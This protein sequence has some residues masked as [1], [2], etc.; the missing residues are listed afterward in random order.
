MIIKKRYINTL[1]AVGIAMILM[2]PFVGCGTNKNIASG[3]TWEVTE[4]T[5]LDSLTI[6]EGA[7]I[8]APEG[9]QLTLT[10]DGVETGIKP[11]TYKGKIV[12]TPT[13]NIP[14]T[15]NMHGVPYILRTGIYVDNGVIVPQKSVSAAVVGGTVTNT[16]A[17]DVSIT[18]I[19]ENFNGIFVTGDSKSS[20]S[21]IN[22][23]INF[24]GNGGSDF[25]ANGAALTSY[26]KADVTVNNASIITNGVI[27]TAVWVGGESTMHVN[28]SNIETGNPALPPGHKDQFTEGGHVMRNVPFMLGLTGTCRSTNLI[29]SGT[30]YYT[31]THIK[32]QGWGALSTDASKDVKLYATKCLI[33]TIESGYGAYALGGSVDTFSGCTFNVADMAVCG[34]GGDSVFTDGT[35]VN[36]RRLGIMYHGSG[37]ITIDKGTV[38][39]SKSTAIQLKAPGHNLIVDNAQIN[40]E[41]GIIV[42]VMANDDPNARG[43]SGGA[44]GDAPAGGARG[45]APAGGA[46]AGGPPAGGGTAARAAR[47][48]DVNATFRNVT[49]KG[50]II[51]GNTAECPV[52][53][54]FE[55]ATITGAIT[56]ATV[57]HA[58]GPNGEE[59]T[60]KTP[61]F[62][63]L[64]GEVTN[65]Y[66]AT[67]D[68]YGITV[69]L[70]ADSKWVVD[71][72]SYLTSLTIANG[73]SITAPE[74][75]SVTMTV[76]GIKKTIGA[77]TYKGKIVLTVTQTA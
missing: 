13:E 9:Q 51:N 35:V 64:I 39:N 10:V 8:K 16:S 30:A 52:S 4:T 32:A 45:A 75:Y 65:T 68:K 29:D 66:S 21:I 53:V 31:N 60:M 20:Y 44:R 12:L 34:T 38:F 71:E 73:A 22:P 70:D 11:G 50:D 40:S 23:K 19:G 69:S 33:E 57:K 7:I 6:A 61:Q 3:S 2:M 1:A 5:N 76:N 26:G 27:R 49:L 74:G 15:D 77:G 58:L 56:T 55:K 62:Y 17:T 14:M 67:D 36:S 41:N 43:F 24:T 28:D 48:S 54:T 25:A 37:D 72:T 59:I 18:S 42:Q 47:S 46:P 63:K